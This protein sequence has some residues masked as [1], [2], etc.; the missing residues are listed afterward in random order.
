MSEHS[1][2]KLKNLSAKTNRIRCSEDPSS[3]QALGPY[4]RCDSTAW[5]H[6]LVQRLGSNA[7]RWP[8]KDGLTL[9]RA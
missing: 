4:R 9:C 5:W 2:S 1:D 7:V 6:A 8:G 3:L